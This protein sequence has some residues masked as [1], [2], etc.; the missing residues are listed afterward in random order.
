MTICEF[1]SSTHAHTHIHTHY[2]YAKTTGNHLMKFVHKVS[3]SFHFSN[4]I[5]KAS[6]YNR[7]AVCVYVHKLNKIMK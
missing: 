2:K 3:L 1:I 7:F 5:K 6:K 4:S